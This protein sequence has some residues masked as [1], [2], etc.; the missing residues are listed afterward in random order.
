MRVCRE[1][2]LTAAGRRATVHGNVREQL[3]KS[4]RKDV[5]KR[6]RGE[7]RREERERA[8]R[9]CRLTENSCRKQRHRIKQ[10][11]SQ[12]CLLAAD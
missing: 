8:G 11:A 6:E 2:E 7:A 1:K 3:T 9:A 12:L 4:N 10:S 5:R